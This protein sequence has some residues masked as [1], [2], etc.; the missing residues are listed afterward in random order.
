MT[1]CTL[2][3]F[4]GT[5]S[6]LATT[7]A[8]RAVAASRAVFLSIAVCGLLYCGGGGADSPKLTQFTTPA[9][10]TTEFA[11]RLDQLRNDLHMPGMAAVI[12]KDQGIAWSQGFGFADVEN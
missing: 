9:K 3:R 5:Q 8:R 4:R 7:P 11:G 1:E 2:S 10:S 6:M 12:A